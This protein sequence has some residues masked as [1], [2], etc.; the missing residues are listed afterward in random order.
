MGD[1]APHGKNVAFGV[2]QKPCCGVEFG[3]VDLAERGLQIGSEY[4]YQARR[5]PNGRVWR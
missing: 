1:A 2:G 4:G 3:V 5:L